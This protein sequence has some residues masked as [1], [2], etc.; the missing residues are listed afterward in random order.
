ME[1]STPVQTH[2]FLHLQWYF[3]M[4]TVHDS[5][6]SCTVKLQLGIGCE[7][8][9]QRDTELLCMCVYVLDGEGLKHTV[10]VL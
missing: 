9:N 5:E 8:L 6:N 1:S 7:E 3:T 4:S 2:L 10:S